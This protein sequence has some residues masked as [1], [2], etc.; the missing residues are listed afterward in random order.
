MLE[1]AQAAIVSIVTAAVLFV[2]KELLPGA[3]KWVTGRADRERDRF[4]ELEEDR[5][6]AEVRANEEA[7]R[8]DSEAAKRR[9]MEEFASALIRKHIAAGVPPDDPAL[10]W[11]Y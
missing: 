7:K 8:A 1:P 6:A 2:L 9:R 4:R 3:L 10:R 5:Q 11:P